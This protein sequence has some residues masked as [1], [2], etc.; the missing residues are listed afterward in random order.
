MTP[1]FRAF[2]FVLGVFLLACV[3]AAM[4]KDVA[5]YEGD[6]YRLTLTDERDGC[7]WH[8]AAMRSRIKFPDRTVLGCYLKVGGMVAFQWDDGA[9]GQMQASELRPVARY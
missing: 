8:P 6:G 9:G 3:P 2:L 1:Y 4:A 7:E 5:F